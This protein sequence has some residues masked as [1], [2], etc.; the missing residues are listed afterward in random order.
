MSSSSLLSSLLGSSNSSSGINISEILQA[1]TGASTPGIDVTG[2]VNAAISAAEAPEKQWEAQQTALQNQATALT[3]IQT[4]ITNLDNDMQSL[5]SLTGPLAG[6]SVT[7]S[8][9]SVV[10]ASAAPGTS[11]GDS[12]VT[13]NNLA[14]TAAWTS[15]TVASSTTALPAESFTITN[16]SGTS[17]T[18]TTDGTQTLS[19]LASEISSAGLGVTASV[20]TDTTGSRLSIVAN[21]SG[22][23]SNFTVSSTDSAD[24]GFTQTVNAVNASL[25]V[26]G[27]DISSASNTVTGALPGVTLNLLSASPGNPPAAVTLNVSANTSAVS[28]AINQFVSDYNTAINAVNAQFTDTGSGEGPLAG[29][30]TITDL[31]NDLMQAVDYTNKPTTGTTTIPNLSSLGI[32]VNKDGT[33][34]VDSTTL[35]SVLANNFSDVQGFFQG[36]ALNGFANTLDQQLT[37]FLSPADGAFTVELQSLTNQNTTLQSDINNFQSNVISPLQTQLQSEF[38][39]AEIALQQ[40]PGEIKDIDAELGMN[41]SSSN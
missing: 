37:S 4:D 36:T 11:V 39:Q 9:S 19:D 5:N 13:V 41:N 32:S 7:S 21:A 40:L 3:A 10:T 35:N 31:Q 23:A 2:A 12:T 29:D 8:N 22:S 6:V 15:G 1:L 33:L 14:T 34:S 17:K 25:Q 20:V 18:I 38:S 27:V 24:F 30:S 26:N 28:T 16:G